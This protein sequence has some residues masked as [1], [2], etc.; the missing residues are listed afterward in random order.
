MTARKTIII[1]KKM[2]RVLVFFFCLFKQYFCFTKCD[3]SCTFIRFKYHS[4][5][6]SHA[7]YNIKIT[8]YHSNFVDF[9]TSFLL[10]FFCYFLFFFP[11]LCFRRLRLFV[12][13][14]FIYENQPV[15]FFCHYRHFSTC[16]KSQIFKI[17]VNRLGF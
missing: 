13:R 16:L 5:W 1:M 3:V 12:F 17:A 6:Q 4:F 9:S 11:C 8:V 2:F 15:P 10:C 14:L 7:N